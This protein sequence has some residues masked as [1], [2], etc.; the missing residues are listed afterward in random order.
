MT[1]TAIQDIQLGQKV[2]EPT[3]DL[4]AGFRAEGV[5]L[6]HPFE[7]EIHLIFFMC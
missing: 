3:V 5:S 4:Q 7:R 6:D 1:S 2:P